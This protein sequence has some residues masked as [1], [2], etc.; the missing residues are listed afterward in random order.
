MTAVVQ[1]LAT[2]W[3]VAGLDVRVNAPPIFDLSLL[4]LLV[5]TRAYYIWPVPTRDPPS[6][7]EYLILV[8]NEPTAGLF[9]TS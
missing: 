8:T 7:Q 9:K 4:A 2:R 1:G 5:P 6:R 3:T